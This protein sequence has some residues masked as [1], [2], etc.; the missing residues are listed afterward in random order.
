MKLLDTVWEILFTEYLS[1]QAITDASHDLGHFQRVARIA[2]QI[3]LDEGEESDPQVLLAAAYFHDIVTLPKDHPEN[4]YSSRYAAAKAV[5][6]LKE[7]HFPEEKLGKVAHAIE[8]HSYSAQIEPTTLEA[9]IIQDADRIEALGAIGILRT[10]YVSG[11]L[12]RAPYDPEDLYAE[13]RPLNDKLFALDHFYVKLFRLPDLM[14]TTVGKTIAHKRAEFL[15]SFIDHLVANIK[16]GQGGALTLILVA[17]HFG[18]HDLPLFHPS[19]P[20]A[21]ARPLE[22]EHFAIDRL[23]TIEEPP[24]KFLPSFLSQLQ[25]ELY[26]EKT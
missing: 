19:D 12:N 11:R 1:Q 15:H 22:P 20:F 26:P 16:E 9:K 24:P 4:K 8:A 25:N 13:R 10:F 7:M 3:A 14:N 6:L 21:T 17:H 23:L 18:A 5:E 2:N